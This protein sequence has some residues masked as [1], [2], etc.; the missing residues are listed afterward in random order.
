MLAAMIKGV[1]I[2]IFLKAI[3]M[4]GLFA[5]W[6]VMVALIVTVTS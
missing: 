2:V 3:G 6:V 5:L 1:C 4:D